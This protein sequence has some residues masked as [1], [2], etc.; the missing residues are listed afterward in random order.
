M[1]PEVCAPELW[2]D[3]TLEPL[4]VLELC[5]LEVFCDRDCCCS[6][7]YILSQSLTLVSKNPQTRKML[8]I[9]KFFSFSNMVSPVLIILTSISIL[10]YS[11]GVEYHWLEAEP[12]TGGEAYSLF[13]LIPFLFSYQQLKRP[14]LM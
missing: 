4:C 12:P 2:L 5:A 7:R 14:F 11:L 10:F 8:V 6:V 9:Y 1:I 13:I 3:S